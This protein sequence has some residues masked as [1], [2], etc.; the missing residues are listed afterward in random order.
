M[1][2]GCVD[3]R[4][5]NPVYKAFFKSKRRYQHVMGGG[6]SGKSYAIA[7]KIV[8]SYLMAHRTYE[9]WYNEQRLKYPKHELDRLISLGMLKPKIRPHKEKIVLLR[10]Q[11]N[12]VRHS[13]FAEIKSIIERH[14]LNVKVNE[15]A[16]TMVAENGNEII[17]LGL[18][19]G[20]AERL[21]SIQG[22]TRF[23][24]EEATDGGITYDD[25][26]QLDTRMRSKDCP[27]S[28]LIFSYNPVH[29]DHWINQFYWQEKVINSDKDL[30]ESTKQ[31]F[32]EDLFKLRTTY[33]DNRFLPK[34][35]IK[36]L[37]A[38]KETNPNFYRVYAEGEWGGTPEGCIYKNWEKIGAFPDA[39][40]KF[41]YGLD[42][43]MNH[44]Y[45]IVKCA[46]L[47]KDVV[48]REMVD[49]K[50]FDIVHEKGIYVQEVVYERGLTTNEII[51]KYKLKLDKDLQFYVSP[52]ANADK[53]DLRSHGYN[54]SNANNDVKD[55]ITFLQ[56][57]RIFVVSNSENR[58]VN[59]ISELQNYKYQKNNQTGNYSDVPDKKYDD[60]MDALRYGIY[61]AFRTTKYATVDMMV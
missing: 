6:G 16:M 5:I 17:C 23:W 60:A 50:I 30:P 46:F 33:K 9:S 7:Q 54:I 12:L 35:F 42:K 52:E 10:S 40:D 51:E 24:I 1:A 38:K 3:S 36:Q 45:A 48:K 14:G 41:V 31:M 57:F 29:E 2:Y 53:K 59:V 49:G 61:T 15:S 26:D 43:G 56:D 34:A 28:C 47:P 18:R 32:R 27:D 4:L 58:S 19:G 20:G 55:G 8:F 11:Q 13:Q 21:K 39:C 22:I 44:P 25:I 37:L